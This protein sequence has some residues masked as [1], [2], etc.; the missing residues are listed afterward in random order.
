MSKYSV[1]R[2][3]MVSDTVEVDAKNPTE[4]KEIAFDLPLDTDPNYVDGS[5]DSDEEI[6]VEQIS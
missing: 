5:M 3:W 4:A 6:D 1:R 2:Y